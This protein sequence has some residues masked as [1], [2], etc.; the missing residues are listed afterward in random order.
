MDE[1]FD[2]TLG[3]RRL[4]WCCWKYSPLWRCCLPSLAFTAQSRIR[5][6]NGLRRWAFVGRWE[7]N[8]VTFLRLILRQALGLTLA[9]VA[10]GLSGAFALTRAMQTLLFQVSPIDPATFTCVAVGFVIVALAASFI[11][12]SH[13]LRIDP[14]AALRYE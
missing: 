2:I 1:V 12:A 6:L 3:H 9:G 5:W 13:A 14:M 11:P 7:R 4:K 8:R 10:V